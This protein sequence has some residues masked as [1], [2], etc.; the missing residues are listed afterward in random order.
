MRILFVGAGA[1][2][3]EHVPSFDFNLAQRQARHRHVDA[4]MDI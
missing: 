2:G 4:A 1:V 3:A